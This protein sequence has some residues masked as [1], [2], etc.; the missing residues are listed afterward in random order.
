[1]KRRLTE[2][3]GK[4]FPSETQRGLS[5]SYA[6]DPDL[7][8]KLSDGFNS[9]T[10]EEQKK[11][12]KNEMELEETELQLKLIEGEMKGKENFVL[13]DDECKIGH[14]IEVLDILKMN[15]YDDNVLVCKNWI[16][17]ER[18]VIDVD[19]LAITTDKKA[20]VNYIETDHNRI[21]SELKEKLYDFKI[22]TGDFE[23]KYFGVW[24]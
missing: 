23:E 17:H 22:V 8:T 4:R 19:Y 2:R 21:K 18:R 5:D 3:M 15:E 9:R 24:L 11:M 13:W 20:L 14:E 6:K 7:F 16:T 10:T 1:M 12:S